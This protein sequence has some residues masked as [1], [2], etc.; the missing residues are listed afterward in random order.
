[1]FLCGDAI[2]NKVEPLTPFAAALMSLA[3]HFAGVQMLERV[4]TSVFT[5]CVAHRGGGDFSGSFVCLPLNAQPVDDSNDFPN[6][7]LI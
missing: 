7:M 4:G 6:Y 5:R 1:M 3:R 2:G